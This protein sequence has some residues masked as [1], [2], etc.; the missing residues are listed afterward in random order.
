MKVLVIGEFC[1]D[2]FVYG[3]VLRMCPEAPVPV[4]NPVKTIKNPGM[5]GNVVANI[6]SI[7]PSADVT[8]F[9]QKG[10]IK[11]T[12][13]VDEKSNQMIVR[14]DDGELKENR[15]VIELNPIHIA[16]IKNCDLVIVSD[17]DKGY[18]TD[19]ALMEIAEHAKLSI[20]DSKRKLS[21]SIINKFSFVKLNKEEGTLNG[22][23]SELPN[24]IVTLGKHG[25]KI[26][27]TTYTQDKPMETID[28]SGAGDTFVAAFGLSYLKSKDIELSIK[29][30]NE[31]AGIVVGKR[32]VAVP[33]ERN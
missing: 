15:D 23:L 24:V 8:F 20:L 25:A 2:E 17:Y 10:T 29:Y 7:E 22:K 30:A 26:N 12:R 28:V 14:I 6:K 33:F 19:A 9:Y 21:E 4:F 32:G 27:G 18:L 1:V 13:I 3:S 16:T 5:A 31:L 11:K